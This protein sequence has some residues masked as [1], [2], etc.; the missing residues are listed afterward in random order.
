MTDL[1]KSDVNVGNSVNYFLFTSSEDLI[2]HKNA[3]NNKK[4]ISGVTLIDWLGVRKKIKICLFLNLQ[5]INKWKALNLNWQ[6]T[7]KLHF[8]LKNK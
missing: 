2:K 8:F 3:K 1:D 4:K 6:G 7:A 5:W